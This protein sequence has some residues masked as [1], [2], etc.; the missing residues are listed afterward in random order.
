MHHDPR[1]REQFVHLSVNG[2]S[3]ASTSG[4]FADAFLGV[5]IEQHEVGSL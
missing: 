2:P 4:R 1:L 3:V 5:E